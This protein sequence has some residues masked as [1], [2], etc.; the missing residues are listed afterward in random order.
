[1]AKERRKRWNEPLQM[2]NRR[3]GGICILPTAE[4]GP[5]K[6]SYNHPLPPAETKECEE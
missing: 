1:V 2:E 3:K 5:M 6:P 4:N